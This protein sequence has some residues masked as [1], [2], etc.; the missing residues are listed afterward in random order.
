MPAGFV[1]PTFGTASIGTASATAMAANPLSQY[2]HIQN[3]GTA[4]VYLRMGTAAAVANEGIRLSAAGNAGDSYE[5]TLE[6][7]NLWTGQINAIAGVAGMKLITL[8]GL[9]KTLAS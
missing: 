9:R 8:D 1:T 6:K 5:M 2:R 4:A 3:D 7:G